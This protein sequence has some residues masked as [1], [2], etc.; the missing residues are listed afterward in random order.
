MAEAYYYLEDYLTAITYYAKTAEIA[1]DNKLILIAK[2]SL[3]WSY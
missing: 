1:Y 2:V 3:G